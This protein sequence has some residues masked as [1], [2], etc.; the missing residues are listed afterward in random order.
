M[1]T[2]IPLG[3][4]CM[5]IEEMDKLIDLVFMSGKIQD[6]IKANHKGVSDCNSDISLKNHQS[7]GSF[8]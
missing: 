7:S 4:L 2:D 1:E 5:R 6:E 8:F 3:G